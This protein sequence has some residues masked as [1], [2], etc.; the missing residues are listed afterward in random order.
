M[1]QARIP[2]GVQAA[3]AGII[4]PL[5]NCDPDMIVEVHIMAGEETLGVKRFRGE[6]GYMVN[7]SCYLEGTLE[8]E[9]YYKD[10]GH[11]YWEMPG[12]LGRFILRFTEYDPAL[13]GP[14]DGA[15]WTETEEIPY[16]AGSE[17][18][19]YWQ[20]LMEMDGDLEICRDETI[21]IP[22]LLN[23]TKLWSVLMLVWG[24]QEIP[25]TLSSDKD[26]N[27]DRMFTY[28]IN[29]PYLQT[30][31][32]FVM[33]ES[34]YMEAR[35]GTSVGDIR[36]RKK[37]TVRDMARTGIRLCWVNKYGTIDYFTFSPVVGAAASL[38][39]TRADG[40]GGHTV[41]AVER[42][43]TVRVES[44]PMSAENLVRLSGILGSRKVWHVVEGVRT[45]VDILTEKAAID[46]T[47][48]GT[49]EI[50]FRY[51]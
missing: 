33:D 11:G 48:P 23:E 18:C 39:K 25:V 20:P 38:T 47:R 9:P 49:M 4:I 2:E 51:C 1:A 17:K 50:E 41:P 37:I 6:T 3:G 40:S 44:P 42:L 45:E 32:E 13:D 16:T 10:V 5:E 46:F 27:M 19:E 43:D 28:Y 12:W 35:C 31:L 8:P 14:P 22:L 29:P 7:A 21:E 34:F 24:E 15:V 36:F 26:G 30:I